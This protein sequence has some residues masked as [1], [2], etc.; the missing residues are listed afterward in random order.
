MLLTYKLGSSFIPIFTVLILSSVPEIL[1][2]LFIYS[3]SPVFCL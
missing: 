3:F 2:I 1:Y